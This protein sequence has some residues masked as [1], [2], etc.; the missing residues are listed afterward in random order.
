MSRSL[1]AISTHFGPLTTSF[2]ILKFLSLW[3]FLPLCNHSTASSR[4]LKWCYLKQ[5]QQTHQQ[6]SSNAFTTNDPCLPCHTG[7]FHPN[8]WRREKNMHYMHSH[9]T[10]VVLGV[11][12]N[13]QMCF[14][15]NAA[16]T[17]SYPAPA[18]LMAVYRNKSAQFK[19]KEYQGTLDYRDNIILSLY[20]AVTSNN[21][22]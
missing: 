2:F 22:F 7:R 5:Q 3:F 13:L 8:E 4:H 19:K 15:N 10:W 18:Y 9:G 12:I 17:T 20:P 16:T 1:L 6:R 21:Y 14:Y 11:E